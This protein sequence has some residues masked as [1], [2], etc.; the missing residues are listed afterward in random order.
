MAKPIIQPR[1]LELEDRTTPAGNITVFLGGGVLNILGDDL[2]NL[3]KIDRLG[4]QSVMIRPLD[5]STTI[6]GQSTP[7]WFG[8][9][10]NGFDIKM[11]GGDDAVEMNKID[12]RWLDVDLGAGDDTL[13]VISSRVNR[14]S[15]ILGGDGDDDLRFF[16]TTFKRRTTIDAGA[17]DDRVSMEKNQVEKNAFVAG[18]AGT[19]S[20]V[21]F[22]TSFPGGTPI[23]NFGTTST[24]LGPR[25]VTDEGTVQ[26]N[27]SVTIDV[28]AND[29]ANGGTLSLSSVTITSNPANGTLQN[30]GNGTITYT[31]N[32]A[33][34]GD[35]F[36]YTIANARGTISNRAIVS[37]NV[38]PDAAVGD[39][40]TVVLTS[41]ESSPTLSTNI[42]VTAVFSEAITGFTQSDIVVTN[43]TISNFSTVNNRT[44]TFVVTPS[45]DGDVTVTIPAASVTDTVGN[46]NLVGNFSINSL[47]TDAGMT[48]VVPSDTDPNFVVGSNGLG[49]WDVT[50]GTGATVATGAS[51][52]IFYTGWLTN[53]T[54]FDS[55]RTAGSPANFALTSLIQG[56]QL[57]VPGMRV[58]GIRRLLIPSNLGY[59]AAGSGSIPPNS[60]LIFEIKLVGI[61]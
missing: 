13:D 37:V 47:R 25:A 51:V 16:N 15:T 61:S 10:A 6:N 50:T 54:V 2:G 21:L 11:G 31:S 32:G 12:A 14:R 24:T 33:A 60:T 23:S 57:G 7:Q 8:D 1:V 42:P 46:P 49:I 35:T 45:A 9:I 56:F 26:Q 34:G 59:G 5:S 53:G 19:N 36:T 40:P 27:Q 22:Q 38:T 41:S 28:A 18:G 58:G 44:F 29:V 3:I 20:I 30:N 4:R 52:R 43:G 17:G 39:N 48:N 55:S